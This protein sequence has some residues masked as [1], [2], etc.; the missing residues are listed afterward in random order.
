MFESIRQRWHSTTSAAAAAELAD[1]GQAT[2][3][4]CVCMF[5]K[6]GELSNMSTGSIS[7]LTEAS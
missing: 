6:Q 3:P 7:I 4:V 2:M 1:T 5:R